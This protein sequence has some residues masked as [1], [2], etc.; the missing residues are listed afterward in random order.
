MQADKIQHRIETYTS[1]L[2]QAVQASH[3]AQFAMLLSLISENQANQYVPTARALEQATG[4]DFR[5]PETDT[6]TRSEDI[7]TPTIVRRFNTAVAEH[8][9]GDFAYLNSHVKTKAEQP[10]I[11]SSGADAFA[12]VSLM[13]AGKLML[14]EI[15][16]SRLVATA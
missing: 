14:D 1:S 10:R 3:G 5:L 2:P 11:S 6:Q 8:L 15:T 13:S 4:T 16:Q 12:K 7:H 9:T